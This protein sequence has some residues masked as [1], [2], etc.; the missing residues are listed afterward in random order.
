MIKVNNSIQCLIVINDL[1]IIVIDWTIGKP[2]NRIRKVARLVE[3]SNG[4]AA[5]KNRALPPQMRQSLYT[6]LSE[7]TCA[8]GCTVR[9]GAGTLVALVANTGRPGEQG[10]GRI[11][12]RYSAKSTGRRD[13][14]IS[15]VGP[16]QDPDC[17]LY[18]T[19]SLFW[20]QRNSFDYILPS[21][22]YPHSYRIQIHTVSLR[23]DL[24]PIACKIFVYKLHLL[25][26]WSY[27]NSY[28]NILI[29]SY[30]MYKYCRLKL[31]CVKDILNISRSDIPQSTI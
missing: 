3:F 25:Y 27:N 29:Y 1:L 11:S 19:S 5:G 18:A 15:T 20:C 9:Q 21:C 7:C 30:W 4:L 24:L 23:T 28:T 22:S 31:L 17:L 13:A 12:D 8:H 16:S 14:A 6:Y 2:E 26:S 10:E